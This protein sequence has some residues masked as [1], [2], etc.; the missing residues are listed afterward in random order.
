[1]VD[2]GI[3]IPFL[4]QLLIDDIHLPV[5]HTHVILSPKQITNV[6]VFFVFYLI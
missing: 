4:F 6:S 5:S 1:M 3:I 2:I